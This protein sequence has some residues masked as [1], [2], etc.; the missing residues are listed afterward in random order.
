MKWSWKIGT[1]SGIGIY[2]HGT[3][4]ILLAYFGIDSLARGGRLI[5]ALGVML[6]LLV[7]FSIVVLHELGHAFAAR[8]YGIQTQDI[9]LLPIGGVAR[10]ERIPEEPKKELVIALAGPAVNVVLAVLCVLGMLLIAGTAFVF[11]AVQGGHRQLVLHLFSVPPVRSVSDLPSIVPYV[12]FQMLI[13][14]VMMV[15]FNLLPAFPMD[16]GRVL[17]ALL[18]MRLNYVN[19]TQVAARIGQSMAVLFGLAALYFHHPML[20]FIAL[21]V[22]I[23]AQAEATQV[24]TR[25]VMG[26]VTAGDAMV[27]RFRTV[28]PDNTLQE[29]SDHIIR[30][31]QQ[32]FPVVTDG[33]VVGMLTRGD[34]LKSLVQGGQEQRVA[35]V[36]HRTFERAEASEQLGRVFERLQNCACHSLPVLRQGQLVG[37]IDM[38]NVG[39]FIAL[40]SAL[41][42]RGE[43]A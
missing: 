7:L 18:A 34:L 19:A 14:N 3:F 26:G 10:L 20:A 12:L 28:T 13:V 6:L 32:D 15:L 31:F 11:G 40:R 24:E 4:L 23:G 43:D 8:H 16:G 1:V 29:V 27:T 5:D 21:F 25:A 37:V 30:G 39:E 2:L 17:R 35:D 9:T 36:M 33:Q 41:R 22:W 38:E 42:N